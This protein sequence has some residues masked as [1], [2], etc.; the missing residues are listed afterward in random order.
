MSAYN[1][2]LNEDAPQWAQTFTTSIKAAFESLSS[3]IRDGNTSLTTKINTLEKKLIESVRLAT[4]KADEALTLAK[5][6][7][8]ILHNFKS[9][10]KC[11]QHTCDNLKQENM[12][13]KQQTSNLE[14]YSRRNN[15][16]LKNVPESEDNEITCETVVKKIMKFHLTKDND[17]DNHLIDRMTFIRCHRLGAQDTNNRRVRPMII[18]FNNFSDRQWIWQ[19]RFLLK[20][21]RF[22]LHENFSG[23]VEYNR[24]K[25]YPI[26]NAARKMEDN[27]RVTLNAD[28][29]IINSVKYT[30][31]TLNELPG[32]LHPRNFTHRANENTHV[33][34]GLLSEFDS[35]SNYGRT[36]F[37]YGDIVYSSSEQAIQHSKALKFKDD[38]IAEKIMM[39]GDPSTAM[40]LGNTV[41]PGIQSS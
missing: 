3:E 6:N 1:L 12:K 38:L 27:T 18:R 2:Q 22:S 9:E 26:Y 41:T 7:S 28:A 35:L 15:L 30:V 5:K 14:S 16:L 39:S 20:D 13:L 37:T 11:L 10:F 4:E 33:F 23:D 36:V 34:G 31:D 24:R 40:Q 25:L 21:S 29:L 19:K 32:K 8:A 17:E